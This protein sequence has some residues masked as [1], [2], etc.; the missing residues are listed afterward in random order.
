MFL[1]LR[2]GYYNLMQLLFVLVGFDSAF[3]SIL[4]VES[5]CVPGDA[6]RQDRRT[7]A[8]QA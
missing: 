2:G 3:D 8:A 4:I 1:E 6:A 7:A 5:L